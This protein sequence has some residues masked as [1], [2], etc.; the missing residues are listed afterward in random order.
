VDLPQCSRAFAVSAFNPKRTLG[1]QSGLT[2]LSATVRFVFAWET[3]MKYR[4]LAAGAALIASPSPA[5]NSWLE[6]QVEAAIFCDSAGCRNVEPTLKLYL[7][8]YVDP[9]GRPQ[10]YY[11]RCRRQG[12]CDRLQNPWVGQSADYRAF[13]IDEAGI[14]SRVG[15]GGK[16]TDVATLNDTVLISRGSCWNAKPQRSKASRA[17]P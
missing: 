11:Y 17:S 4:V 10:S 1:E 7:G 15:P 2:V 14:I 6:C 12:R 5:A 8:D 13:V 9:K 16:L 3:N